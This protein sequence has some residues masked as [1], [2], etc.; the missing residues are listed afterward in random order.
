MPQS[1]RTR[2]AE[3]QATKYRIV[4]AAAILGCMLPVA[5]GERGPDYSPRYLRAAAK[6]LAGN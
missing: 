3:R 6:M 4:A 2:P 1:S 5:C